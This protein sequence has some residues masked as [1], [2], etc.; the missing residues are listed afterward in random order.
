M[1][2]KINTNLNFSRTM[3]RKTVF[4]ID[5]YELEWVR[6]ESREQDV[7]TVE[8]RTREARGVTKRN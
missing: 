2:R 1:I 8:R 4:I 6:I 3:C 7:R 5:S